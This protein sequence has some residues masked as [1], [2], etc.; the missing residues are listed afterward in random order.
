MDGCK[1][2]SRRSFIGQGREPGNTL[3]RHFLM[4]DNS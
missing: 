4:I 1:I 3:W 2:T